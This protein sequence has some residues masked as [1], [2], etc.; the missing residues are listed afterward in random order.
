MV[1]AVGE[2]RSLRTEELLSEAGQKVDDTEGVARKTTTT[3]VMDFGRITI[4]AGLRTY[5]AQEVPRALDLDRGAPWCSATH[6]TV[7]RGKRC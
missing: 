7:T 3:V 5:G 4:R 6:G 1:G 2:I